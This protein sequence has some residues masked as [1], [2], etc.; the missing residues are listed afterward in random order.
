VRAEKQQPDHA[1]ARPGGMALARPRRSP[2]W[3]SSPGLPGRSA[4]IP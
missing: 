2:R 4:C 1:G 3:R